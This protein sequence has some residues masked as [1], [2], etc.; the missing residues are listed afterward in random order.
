MEAGLET[1]TRGNAGRLVGALLHHDDATDVAILKLNFIVICDH[2][3]HVFH[4]NQPVFHW[5]RMFASNG[6]TRKCPIRF[7]SL[8]LCPPIL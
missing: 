3:E 1:Q 2:V 4:Q 6:T 8:L 5:A 7:F